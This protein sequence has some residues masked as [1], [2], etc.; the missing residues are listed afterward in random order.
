MTPV[1]ALLIVGIFMLGAASGSVLSYIQHRRLI[2]AYRELLKAL[3]AETG[4]RDSAVDLSQHAIG[5][6][7]VRGR[8]RWRRP[9]LS[10]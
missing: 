6:H 1:D 2:A 3:P 8:R 5:F 10:K 4:A 9:T 7:S